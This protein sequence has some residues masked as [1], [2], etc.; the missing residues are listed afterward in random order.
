MTV[1]KILD[2]IV[3]PC[4]FEHH[5]KLLHP[6]TAQHARMGMQITTITSDVIKLVTY[7]VEL[8]PSN[9]RETVFSKFTEN[10]SALLDHY[11]T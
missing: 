10:V 4:L 7:D 11:G 5:W 2:S 9:S 8:L 3:E 6:H 1:H